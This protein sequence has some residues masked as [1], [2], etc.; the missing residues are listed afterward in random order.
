M[1]GGKYGAF[2]VSS[3]LHCPKTNNGTVGHVKRDILKFFGHS[4][5]F[6]VKL[7]RPEYELLMSSSDVDTKISIRRNLR[8]IGC[9]DYVI[10]HLTNLANFNALIFRA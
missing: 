1:T 10:I 4:L 5:A 3:T 9:S 8:I 6:S 2:E 7:L